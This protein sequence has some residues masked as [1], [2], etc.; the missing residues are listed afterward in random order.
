MLYEAFR[1]GIITEKELEKYL[2][3]HDYKPTARPGISKSDVQIVKELTY[4]IPTR[5]EGRMMYEMGLL[6]DADIDK[7][8]KAEGIHPDWRDK[9]KDFIKQFALR[10]DLRRIERE[11]RYLF[12]QEKIDES[13]YRSYLSKARVPQQFH[14]LF[15]EL[16][17]LEKLRK[18]REAEMTERSLTYSQFANAFRRGIINEEEFRARLRG[19]GYADDVVD[20]LVDIEIDRKYESLERQLIDAIEDLYEYNLLD[21]QTFVQ[22]L[23]DLN[24]DETEI[25]LRKQIR[26]LRRA[27]RRKKLTTTQVLKALKKNIIDVD[28]AIQYLRALGYGDFEISVLLQLY[29]SELFE[30]SAE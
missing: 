9:F 17:R 14:D 2:V 16:A 19:L 11:A 3:W 13:T 18:Q 5:T 1:R 15:V 8:V 24:L 12:I 28:T 22:M 26:D 25:S 21:E 7:I 4:R 29:V 6:T 27:R 23:K 20:L 30:V 10:D